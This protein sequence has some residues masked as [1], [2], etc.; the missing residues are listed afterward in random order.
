MT[1]NFCVRILLA[2]LLALVAL[3]AR[4]HSDVVL[5]APIVRS[6][7]IS[8]YALVRLSDQINAP[9]TLKTSKD[10]LEP[11]A[12]DETSIIYLDQKGAIW[13]LPAGSDDPVLLGATRFVPNESPIGKTIL[14]FENRALFAVD[15]SFP[16]KTARWPDHRFS[17]AKYSFDGQRT[18]IG[19]GDGKAMALWRISA[20]VIEVVASKGL[21]DYD[22]KKR[23]SSKI[24][25]IAPSP[26][27]EVVL[28]KSGYGI[29]SNDR[30]VRVRKGLDGPLVAEFAAIGGI[31][32]V[33]DIDADAGTVL[34][35]YINDEF[36]VARI[37]E[38]DMRTGGVR[39][40]YTAKGIG[41]ARYCVGGVGDQMGQRH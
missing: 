15:N 36:T 19:S 23:L 22:L 35:I 9:I 24:A 8:G 17:I 38:L 10:P 16:G 27:A 6:E 30:V 7:D 28:V 13:R 3:S 1:N 20:D 26:L 21:V 4:G 37:D 33:A 34:S 40:R 31:R 32:E 39:E 18:E 25:P 2:N 41:T 5:V 29:F 11:L 12:C 14:D